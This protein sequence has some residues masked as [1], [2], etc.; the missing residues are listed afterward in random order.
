MKLQKNKKPYIIACSECGSETPRENT[1]KYVCYTCLKGYG[2]EFDKARKKLIKRDKACKFCGRKYLLTAHHK[3]RNTKNNKLNNL[4]LLCQ[5]CH[6]SYHNHGLTKPIGFIRGL[7]GNRL[8][9]DREY[10]KNVKYQSKKPSA[11]RFF[12]LQNNKK[13]EL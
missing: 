7:F 11:K 6:I 13:K 3:D 1:R 8:I 9:Y 2:T 4:M 5:P 10:W 12:K